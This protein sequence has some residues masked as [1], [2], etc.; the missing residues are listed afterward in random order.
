MG[1]EFGCIVTSTLDVSMVAVVDRGI[2]NYF[3]KWH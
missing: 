2:E 1:K 3:G